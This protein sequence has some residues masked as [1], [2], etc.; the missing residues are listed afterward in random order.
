[1]SMLFSARPPL[2]GSSSPV[3]QRTQL[4]STARSVTPVPLTSSVAIVPSC[5]PTASVAIPIQQNAVQL[6]IASTPIQQSSVPLTIASPQAIAQSAADLKRKELEL[7]V[8]RAEVDAL[9]PLLDRKKKILAVEKAREDLVNYAV[10][11]PYGY[12]SPTVLDARMQKQRDL[13]AKVQ[14]AEMDV[15]KADYDAKHAV[16]NHEEKVLKARR[17]ELAL[18]M[19]H[20]G[21]EEEDGKAKGGDKKG[22]KKEGKA[23]E[24]APETVDREN[25]PA[26]K[27]K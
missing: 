6:T 11:T 25:K 17:A 19:F 26:E 15:E 18:M 23:P 20:A 24:T 22:G 9:K 10:P 5:S 3:L 13:E 1:M 7:K 4:T 27:P 16:L 12:P 21:L 8:K 2:V 14:A